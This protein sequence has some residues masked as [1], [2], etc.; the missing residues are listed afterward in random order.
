MRGTSQISET[1]M[2]ILLLILQILFLNV[3]HVNG[4]EIG[5]LDELNFA[6]KTLT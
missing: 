3:V 5:C 1:N 2:M 6:M 4:F